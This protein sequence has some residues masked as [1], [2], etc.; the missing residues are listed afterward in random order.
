VV[1]DGQEAVLVHPADVAVLNQP[2][3]VIAPSVQ[4]LLKRQVAIAGGSAGSSVMP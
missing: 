1:G 3:G 4:A 2:R